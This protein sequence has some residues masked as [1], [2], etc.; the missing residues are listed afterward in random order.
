MPLFA[1]HIEECDFKKEKLKNKKSNVQN[2]NA[3]VYGE[4]LKDEFDFM[5]KTV[6]IK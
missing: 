1:I 2:L 3:T 5:N 6:L 4:F